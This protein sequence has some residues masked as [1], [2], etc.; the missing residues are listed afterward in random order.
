MLIGFMALAGSGRQR[1]AGLWLTCA[2]LVF[3]GWW[4]PIYVPLLLVSM[5]ANFTL[6]GMLRRRPSRPL[7]FAGI[8][9]NILLLVYFKYTGFLVQVADQVTGAD[10][11][12]PQ[13]VLPLAI[14]FYTFQQIAYLSDAHDGAVGEHD[15]LNY[16]LFITFFPHLIAGPI[17]HHREMLDQFSNPDNFRPRFDNISVGA[18]LFVLGLFKKVVFADPLGAEA[19]PVF[20]AATAGAPMPLLDA[21]TG[22]LAYTLQLY[23]DFSGYS[24]MAIGLGL[25]FGISL[26]ANFDSPF[27]APNIIQFWARWHMTLTRFLTAYIYNPLVLRATRARVAAGKPLPRKGKMSVGTFL[28]LVAYPTVATLMISGIWHGAGW[29]FVIFGALHAFYLVVA[30]AWRAYK[31]HRGWELDSSNPIKHGAAVLTT[32]LCVVV[33]SVFFRSSD[34]PAALNMLSGMVGM[35]GVQLSPIL[36]KFPMVSEIAAMLGI[37]V[38]QPAFFRPTV[39]AQIALLLLFVWTMPNTQQWLQHYRTALAWRPRPHWLEG[40]LPGMSWRPSPV[41]AVVI[42]VVGFYVLARAMSVAPTEF[43]Y[44]QF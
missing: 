21:W 11:V 2:S 1:L 9:A 37:E 14:S 8:A 27:K 30:N 40:V 19:A 35:Q 26:P 22:A 24:D 15:F 7:L 12:A 39:A 34:V 31:A 17:T 10:W 42:G 3:Y 28:T 16:C 5:G 32:F 20:A 43:L 29:Q 23:F 18:T 44:F 33:G 4:N 6:G 25:L 36:A 38:S 13:I 41:Y